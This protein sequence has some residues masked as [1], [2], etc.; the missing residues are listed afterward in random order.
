[1]SANV[2]SIAA[3]SS[4]PG[5]ASQP[6]GGARLGAGQRAPGEVASPGLVQQRGRSLPVACPQGEVGREVAPGAVE[7]GVT[8]DELVQRPAGPMRALGREHRR[9][10]GVV[11]EGVV[12][13][14]LVVA[15]RLDQARHGGGPQ[16]GQHVRFA[17]AQRAGQQ[18]PVEPAVPAPRP[19]RHNGVPGRRASRACPPP[20]R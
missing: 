19:P 2:S 4:V 6:R 3:A 16:R 13:A 14:E 8:G 5:G 1:V 18:A 15:F 7:V 11:A 20:A 17:V 9:E 12:E 10:H